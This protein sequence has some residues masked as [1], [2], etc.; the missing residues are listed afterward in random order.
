MPNTTTLKNK[1][2]EREKTVCERENAK[3]E[4]EGNA[5]KK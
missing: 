3:R 1:E 4:R 2:N 5:A